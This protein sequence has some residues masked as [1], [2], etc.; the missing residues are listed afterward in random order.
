MPDISRLETVGRTRPRKSLG[1]LFVRIRLNRRAQRWQL[2]RTA[3]RPIK[4]ET[5]IKL[6]LRS[7]HLLTS[8]RSSF[9]KVNFI[10][11]TSESSSTCAC[12]FTS[13]ST[14]KTGLLRGK[15]W[16]KTEN[17][18]TMPTWKKRDAEVAN[19]PLSF[20][21]YMLYEE[22]AQIDHIIISQVK[23]LGWVLVHFLVI[24]LRSLTLWVLICFVGHLV[25]VENPNTKIRDLTDICPIG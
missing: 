2:F 18:F 6:G 7:C 15:F 16:S 17:Y 8:R 11:L 10:L 21:T 1:K 25:V 19:T 22:F 3:E 4:K 20:K 24:D 14:I 23:C 5:A 12:L 13:T 9:P